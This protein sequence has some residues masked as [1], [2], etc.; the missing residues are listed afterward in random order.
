MRKS[1]KSAMFHACTLQ[2]AVANDMRLSAGKTLAAMDSFLRKLLR[3]IMTDGKA[4][5]V[6]N[7]FGAAEFIDCNLPVNEIPFHQLGK[8]Y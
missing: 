4:W 5:N 1:T 6:A 8:A 2:W 3:W 7:D